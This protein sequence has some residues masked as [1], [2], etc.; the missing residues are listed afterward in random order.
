MRSKWRTDQ[1]KPACEQ[2]RT[3]YPNVGLIDRLGATPPVCVLYVPAQVAALLGA[4]SM[5]ASLATRH[6]PIL[7]KATSH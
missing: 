6:L 7:P 5:M 3:L 4:A 2:Q 1:A